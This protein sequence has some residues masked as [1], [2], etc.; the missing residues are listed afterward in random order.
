MMKESKMKQ[1]FCQSRYFKNWNQDTL[2]EYNRLVGGQVK[3]LTLTEKGFSCTQS[4]IHIYYMIYVASLI[5]LPSHSV[6]DKH[7]KY[8]FKARSKKQQLIKTKQVCS[9]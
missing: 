5:L 9:G 6:T 7:L 2:A 3:S 1:D 4:F 8:F